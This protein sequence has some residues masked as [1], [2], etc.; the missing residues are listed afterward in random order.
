MPN[1]ALLEP[2]H[3]VLLDTLVREAKAFK[4]RMEKTLAGIDPSTKDTKEMQ[5]AIKAAT[6]I[7]LESPDNRIAGGVSLGA[8]GQMSGGLIVRARHDS[9]KLS[10]HAVAKKVS[11]L[12]AGATKGW[13]GQELLAS[14]SD[15]LAKAAKDFPAPVTA[16]GAPASEPIGV[17]DLDDL[18]NQ[19]LQMKKMGGMGALMGMMPGMGQMKKAMAGANVDEKIF[20]RQVAIINSM[21]KAERANPDVLKHSR[22]KR[23]AAGSGTDAAEINKLL[24]MHRQMADMMKAM[25]GKKGGGMMKQMMGGLAGKM[26]LG[27]MGGGMGGMGGGMG[28]FGGGRNF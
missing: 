12:Q 19:L 17:F 11:T 4:A 28:G 2:P 21:T 15:E 18:R 16:A 22:K 6:G 14:L 8:A 5:E 9:K 23:I 26:G 27:G 3:R 10:A 13:N 25:G 1:G 20:D 7:D 24:K